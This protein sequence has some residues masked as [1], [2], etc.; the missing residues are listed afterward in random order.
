MGKRHYCLKV[1][2]TFHFP[3]GQTLFFCFAS[4]KAHSAMAKLTKKDFYLSP[5][6]NN[7][8]LIYVCGVRD[9]KYTCQCQIL[10]L[11]CKKE[12]RLASIWEAGSCTSPSLWGALSGTKSSWLQLTPRALWRLSTRQGISVC[13]QD[14]A[15]SPLDNK[16]CS[17][18]LYWFYTHKYTLAYL[19]VDHQTKTG[20]LLAEHYA[21][22]LY[23]TSNTPWDTDIGRIFSSD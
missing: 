19:V 21:T 1:V 14:E 22:W 8:T 18:S 11:N 17:A 12:G 6:S 7:R 10:E 15:I 20:A 2:L 4:E 9:T 23:L 16:H 13:F 5:L 3:W